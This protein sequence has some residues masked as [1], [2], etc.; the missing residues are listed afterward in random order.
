MLGKDGMKQCHLKGIDD[1]YKLEG[2]MAKNSGSEQG[3]GNVLRKYHSFIVLNDRER[4]EK[5]DKLGVD[6]ITDTSGEERG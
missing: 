4:G 6:V 5:A 3:G 2:V 1:G